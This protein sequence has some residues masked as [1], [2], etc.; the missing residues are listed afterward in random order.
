LQDATPKAVSHH[1]GWESSAALQQCLTAWETRLHALTSEVRQ[2]GSNLGATS[3]AYK[4]A[5][6]KAVAMIEQV[7]KQLHPERG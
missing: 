7:A 2:I 6:R 1:S 4:E 5:E 3:E